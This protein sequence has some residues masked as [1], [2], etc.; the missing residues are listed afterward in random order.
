VININE[1]A[2]CPWRQYRYSQP[3]VQHRGCRSRQ[4]YMVSNPH[5]DFAFFPTASADTRTSVRV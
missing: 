2:G 5:Y 1:D 4:D 3:R